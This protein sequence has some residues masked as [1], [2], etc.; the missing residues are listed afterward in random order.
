LYTN[1]EQA[2]KEI[3]KIIPFAITSKKYRGINLT[4]EGK[5]TCNENYKTLKKEIEGD[6]KG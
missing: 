1:N 2:E 3:G 6:N 4:K 5:N